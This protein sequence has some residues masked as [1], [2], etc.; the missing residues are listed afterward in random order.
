M[1]LGMRH[2]DAALCEAIWIERYVFVTTGNY[3]FFSGYIVEHERFHSPE[4][5]LA[6][7]KLNF[8]IA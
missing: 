5:D 7:V 4:L 2:S 3:I 6:L 1:C 8:S